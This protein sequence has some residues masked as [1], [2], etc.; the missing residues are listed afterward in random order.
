MHLQIIILEF[1]RFNVEP[2][3]NCNYDF[4]QIFDGPSA[5]HRNIGKFCN[6]NLPNGGT[7]KSTTNEMFLS[8]HSDGTVAGDGFTLTWRSALPGLFNS[9]LLIRVI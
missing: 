6:N 3:S 5:S 1:T 7:I 2:D 4:L 9:F 8:F